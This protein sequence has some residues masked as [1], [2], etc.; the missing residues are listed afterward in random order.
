MGLNSTDQ[1]G[2]G[3]EM[4]MWVA[5]SAETS[6]ESL[7]LPCFNFWPSPSPCGCISASCTSQQQSAAG[8]AGRRSPKP[9]V[10]LVF[11]LSC[12]RVRTRAAESRLLCCSLGLDWTLEWAL[13]WP[14]VILRLKGL[15]W[16]EG[17]VVVNFSGGRIGGRILGWRPIAKRPFHASG[18]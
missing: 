1:G 5:P 17:W 15:D 2:P 18:T 16:P 6:P 10:F 9:L 8:T 13:E 7:F 4:E 14:A 12:L 3:N 11:F